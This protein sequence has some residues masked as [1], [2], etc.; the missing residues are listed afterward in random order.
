[1]LADLMVSEGTI[2]EAA[3]N[4]LPPVTGTPVVATVAQTEAANTVLVERWA[5]E[6]GAIE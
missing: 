5:A 3:F 2:D 6:V 1:V 4:A